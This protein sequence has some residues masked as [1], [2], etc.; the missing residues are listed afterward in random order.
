VNKRIILAT[1]SLHNMAGGLEKNIIYLA[2]HLAELGLK[3]SLVTFDLQGAQ[4]FYPLDKWVKW[5]KFGIGQPHQPMS[6][7]NRLRVLYR[8]RKVLTDSS[9]P[10]TLICFHHGILVR[11]LAASA[12]SG[13][14]IICS[15]RTSLSLYKFIIKS[16][17]NLN[18]A[19]LFLVNRITVQFSSYIKSYPRLLQRKIVCVHNPV[20][21]CMKFSASPRD[22]MILSVGRL[23]FPKQFDLLILACQKVFRKHPDWKLVIIGDG[24]KQKEL[25]AL[26]EKCS[27][28]NKVDL[29]EPVKDLKPYFAKASFYCQPSLWEGFPNAMAEAMACGVVPIGF[30]RTSG[31]A[32]LIKEGVNGYLCHEDFTPDALA[33]TINCAIDNRSD[34]DRM[35]IDSMGVVERYSPESWFSLWRELLD[36]EGVIKNHICHKVDE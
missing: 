29:I 31:V 33:N 11:C 1:I 19:M 25:E 23:G 5:H 35:S 4:A 18:F 13:V 17:W 28:V 14:K 32:D 26:I 8:M 30:S 12:F 20:F 15:E 3:V 34:Y 2:N 7:Y 9:D 16:K 10:T 22:K 36:V 6:F 24:E 27:L 21:K